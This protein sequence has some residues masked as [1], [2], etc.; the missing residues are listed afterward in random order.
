MTNLIAASTTPSILAA[1][2]A[3]AARPVSATTTLD[4]LTG[5]LDTRNPGV[6]RVR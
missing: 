1:R 3:G 6:V 5:F 2:L 4:A